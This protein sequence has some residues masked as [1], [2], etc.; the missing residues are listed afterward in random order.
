MKLIPQF[1]IIIILLIVFIIPVVFS[2]SI[3]YIEVNGTNFTQSEIINITGWSDNSSS[4]IYLWN[5]YTGTLQSMLPT[6]NGTQ[7]NIT[8]S[9]DLN[10]GVYEVSC[11]S[12]Y[13]S[14]LSTKTFSVL[15]VTTTITVPELTITTVE[16]T[17]NTTT[18]PETTAV[19]TTIPTTSIILP[20]EPEDK[21]P[22]VWSNL[23]H[24]PSVVKETDSVN[25][26][27]D[28]FD[29]L[30]LDVVI[31]YENST[32]VWEEHVCDKT[33]GRCS[34]GIIS[35]SLIST[36]LT[37]SF[38]IIG[39]I[40][41]FTVVI[42]ILIKLGRV[43]K[44]ILP[45]L[46]IVIFIFL[47]S[48]FLSPEL[49]RNIS[50]AF[51][52]LGI[53]PRIPAKTFS[54]TI[55]TSNLNAGE[56]VLYYSYANDT[57]ENEV[58]TE[59]NSFTVQSVEAVTTET[60]IPEEIQ[61]VAVKE[62][63]EKVE[64]D[65]PVKWKKEL[66]ISNPSTEEIKSYKVT[67]LPTNAKNIIVKDDTGKIIYTDKSSWETNIAG[68][69]VISYFVEY[70]TPPP[71][72]EES[73]I[74]PF[75]LG[76]KYE[77]RIKV[78]SDFIEHYNNVKAYTDIPE[79]LSQEK[80]TIKLYHIIDN[81]K[82][83]VTDNPS[84]EVKFLDS[85][86]DGLN[87]RIEWVVP[88]LSEEEFGVEASITI[89]NVQSYPT[90]WGNWTVRFNTTGTANLTITPI[91]NT[92][93]DVDLQFL[94]LRCGNNKVNPVYDG[95][96][97]SYENW[98]CSEEG[99][100]INKVLKEGKHTLEFRFGDDVEYAYNMA[101]LEKAMI[102]YISNTLSGLN[103][104]KI[105]VWNNETG[106]GGEIELA[107]AGSPVRFVRLVFSPISPKRIIIT[108][109]DDGLLD[110]YVSNDGNSWT[111]SNDIGTVGVA[112]QRRFDVKF[113]TATGD[114]IVVYAINSTD[115]SRD[116]AYKVLSENT[117]SFSGITEQYINDDG[118][119]TN[120]QYYWIVMDR[121]PV[122]TSEEI[123]VAG[124]DYTD[125][126][127]DAWIWN[128]NAWV[129]RVEISSS[130]DTTSRSYEA[131]AV[132]YANDGSKGMI[133]GGDATSGNVN[134]Q[135][136]NGA[137]WT[138]SN[139]GDLN[140]TNVA[141]T[142]WLTLKSDPSTDDLMAVSVDS[143][144]NLYTMYWNGNSWSITRNIDS[145]GIDISTTRPVDFAWNPSG[146]TGILIWDTD[147]TGTTLSYRT[148]SPE[149]NSATQTTSTYAG[150]GRWIQ[151]VTNP[152]NEDNTKILIGRLN[153]N[154]DIG[155][156]NRSSTTFSNY[157]DSVITANTVVTTYEAFDISFLLVEPIINYGW[158]N[159]TLDNPDPSVYKDSSPL[160][161]AQYDTFVVNATV[162]CKEASC[163]TVSGSLRYNDSLGEPN[164]IISTTEGVTP[165]YIAGE[166]I[167]SRD[168][169]YIYK[170]WNFSVSNKMT[171]PTGIAYNGTYFWVINFN[172][173][174]IFR[175]NK[176][177]DYDG[178][179]LDCSDRYTSH[180]DGIYVNDTHIFVVG[181]KD[182]STANVSIYDM[183]GNFIRGFNTI[184]QTT[185]P[186]SVIHN[187]TYF[188]VLSSSPGN[189]Y[190]YRYRADG[191]YDS[192]SFQYDTFGTVL[193]DGLEFNGTHFFISS[194]FG[195][196]HV[197]GYDSN[198]N[199][200]YWNFTLPESSPYGL[201]Y[202]E[203][204]NNFYTA[205]LTDQ[206]V[207]RY[208]KNIT[209]TG[210]N[211]IS[212]G[213]LNQGQKCQLNWT[214]SVTGS[215]DDYK[216]DVN[217]SSSNYPDVGNN[218]TLNSYIR[219][220][221]LL[222]FAI[223]LP[224]QDWILSSKTEP[225]T[226][227]TP[228]EFNATNPTD[229]NVQPCVVGYG[230]APGSKQDATTPIFTFNNTG[231]TAEQWNISLSKSLSSYGITLYGNTSLDPN[232]YEITT[233]GWI[234]ANSVLPGN[235]V[236]AWLWA[237]F[238]NSPAGTVPD[239]FI[240]HSSLKA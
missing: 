115:V 79:E 5:D 59:I 209:K 74:K 233:S 206:Y 219:I 189:R 21:E 122:S 128:G 228:V 24:E 6:G 68:K 103:T 89:I 10:T 43:P 91:N 232:L 11:N 223:Q 81:S 199:Y 129:N 167:Q 83:D 41:T 221:G 194:I 172:P 107:S 196:G 123:I 3:N 214:V 65:K 48:I 136:W 63:H 13:N 23:R 139:I 86:N 197:Y 26:M 187:G 164:I 67:S 229:S 42:L 132:K 183:N 224:G 185:S 191:T 101:I 226:L 154:N 27:V 31:I 240:N 57:A 142:R 55:P 125:R 175:Y 105:R 64:I 97:V 151:A 118:H 121:N 205:D 94:E 211:P 93:F 34:L 148:C 1:T 82:I 147:T 202:S 117:L 208:E 58:K 84:Y 28:W 56:V 159:V 20:S 186:V 120:I 215:S 165:F 193:G 171:Q 104:P 90:V 54:H 33:T 8:L 124:I 160:E 225:G 44:I 72:K 200:V 15:S 216:I 153:R 168:D 2:Q 184:G 69:K 155:A 180:L 222:P 17:V 77:K 213:V 85:D 179:S 152:R 18:I 73:V 131:L 52:R 141:D 71:Y 157:G 217:F 212:C 53:V 9:Y 234:A 190:V 51:S 163:G 177:G 237:N 62:E 14:T 98:S 192:W 162:E 158:L 119:A 113:E 35:L 38:L 140:S 99:R 16:A 61:T 12:T 207:R 218:D 161:V 49:S 76:K 143:S 220:G 60:T 87:D 238:V 239:V 231:N 37:S 22:P 174:K 130:V 146:S 78:K 7:T 170:N 100:I 210:T 116:L 137:S 92:N 29:K 50:R 149:C 176:T 46:G 230:C 227:T 4:D 109:S 133:I 25:I 150:T 39:I 96:S 204:E 169:D 127:I 30:G 236:Q 110:A 95:K 201:D 88:Q 19:I 145:V 126:D 111:F 114:A 178:W 188:W 32:G 181:Y 195:G 36:D 108:Q 235:T 156:I 40:A 66:V 182:A 45:F 173:A 166:D 198:G 70:E 134:G 135:Y 138:T 47:L 203:S 112:T 144:S 75:V 102:A 106:W 80:Y